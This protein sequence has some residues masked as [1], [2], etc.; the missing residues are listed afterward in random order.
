VSLVREGS[1][2]I[3]EARTDK[4]GNFI[5]RVVPGRYGIKAIANGFSESV[6]AK[7]D[8]KA[9]QELAIA[10][11]SSRLVYGNTL[12]RTSPRS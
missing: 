3:K 2:T 4:Q 9:Q 8:V 7:V 6:F 11:T 10:S 5:A 12:A 1:K